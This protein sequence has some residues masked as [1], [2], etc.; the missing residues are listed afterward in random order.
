MS[1]T[2][3]AIAEQ[4]VR[5]RASLG[6]N[7]LSGTGRRKHSMKR[8]A[9]QT[10]KGLLMAAILLYAGDWAVFRIRDMRG[11]A[12]GTVQADQFLATPLKGNKEEYDYMGTEA[13]SCARS[14]FPHDS[15]PACWWVRRHKDHWE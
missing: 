14:L 5:L 2:Q 6:Y 3:R 15:T 11:S 9:I 10:L 4:R 1:L 13:V 7:F 8:I 12:F